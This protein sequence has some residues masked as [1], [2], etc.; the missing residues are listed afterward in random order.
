MD[1][2]KSAGIDGGVLVA[3]MDV[4]SVR[5][6]A[7][8]PA[9]VYL[10]SL[11]PG[12]RSAMQS[13]LRLVAG[14][15]TGRPASDEA[16]AGF[17][18]HLLTNADLQYLRSEVGGRYS[19]N[20]ANKIMAAVKGVLKAAWRAGSMT[21]DDYRRAVDLRPVTGDRLPAG[22]ALTAG[23]LRALFASCGSS[24]LDVRDQAM[25]AVLYGCG[26]RRAELVAL[27]VGD[28]DRDS[29]TLRIIGKGNKERLCHLPAAAGA[30]ID[31]WLSMRG[32]AGGVLFGAAASKRGARFTDRRMTTHAVALVLQRRARSAGV[33][34]FTPHDL[35]RTFISALL[36]AGADV[37]TVQRMAGHSRVETTVRYDR[38][39]EE[40]KARAAQ[41]IHLPI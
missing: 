28:Y 17:N 41:L 11:S 25:L 22:R 2:Q 24:A 37:S 7:P 27:T 8:S 1:N 18:W 9:A 30:L 26:L 14:S 32:T 38:R 13:A 31:A 40:A 15:F 33:A 6:A 12:S 5:S 4:L 10:A 35:R 16:A 20:Y 29:S 36:D 34:R 39:P 19:A 23:E 3:R 21:S